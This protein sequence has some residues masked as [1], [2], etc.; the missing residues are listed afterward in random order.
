M[1]D[2]LKLQTML[3]GIHGVSGMESR[4]SEVISEMAKPYADEIK[5]DT[6][7]NLIVY[8]KSE[9]GSGSVPKKVMFS[10]HMDSIG[11]IATVIDENGFVRFGKVGGIDPLEIMGINVI[12]AGGV[13]GLVSCDGKEKTK[14]AKLENLYIDIGAALQDQAKKLVRPGD[15]FSY[16]SE[17]YLAAGRLVSPYLDDRIGCAVLL[18]ALSEI[19]DS[20]NDLYFVFSVQ[21]EV[22][23][24]GAKTAAFG[25]EPDYALAVDVTGTGDTPDVSPKMDCALGGG[26]AIKIMD[27]SVICHPK[28]VGL[29]ESIAQENGIKAQREILE[30]GGT[31]AGPIHMSRAGVVTGAV[32]IPS[33]YIHTPTEMADMEDI[34]ACVR[35]VAAFARTMLD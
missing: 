4:I 26:A 29:L 32:S 13:R 17:T 1:L 2:I 31:D 9:G 16:I 23:T 3:A 27:R 21:E 30:Y 6:L 7:G 24:R 33:R 25:V 20:P 15:T 19:A 11:L 8:K 22:G 14:D 35:L 5:T 34:E 28:M 10:A 18:A 12:S